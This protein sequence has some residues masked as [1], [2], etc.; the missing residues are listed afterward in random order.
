[1]VI[2]KYK[3]QYGFVP[4]TSC[5]IPKGQ[6]GVL[7]F[8]VGHTPWTMHR[9][10]LQDV[11]GAVQTMFKHRLRCQLLDAEAPPYKHLL[12]VVI[13]E[14]DNK[15]VKMQGQINAACAGSQ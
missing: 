10:T 9:A 5:V 2:L 1:M 15:P 12:R 11:V 3:G 7:R 13:C 6:P 14:L 8:L 4:K